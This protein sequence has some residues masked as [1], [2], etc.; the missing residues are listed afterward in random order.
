MSACTIIIITKNPQCVKHK[1]GLFLSERE[2]KTN[3]S[4]ETQNVLQKKTEEL[5]VDKVKK[6]ISIFFNTPFDRMNKL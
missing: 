4:K 6:Q 3:L 5:G 2:I 1:G